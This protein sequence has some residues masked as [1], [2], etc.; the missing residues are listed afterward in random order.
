MLMNIDKELKIV[1]DQL[2]TVPLHE[3]T[4]MDNQMSAMCQNSFYSGTDFSL[5]SI[6]IEMIVFCVQLPLFV[7]AL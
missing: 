3:Y 5:I 6:F 2:F 7:V 4:D 1:C